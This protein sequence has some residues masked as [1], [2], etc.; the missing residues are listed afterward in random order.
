[1][2]NTSGEQLEQLVLNNTEL[3]ETVATLANTSTESIRHMSKEFWE[4][5]WLGIELGLAYQNSQ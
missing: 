5:V 2:S 4:W 1:V 3:T